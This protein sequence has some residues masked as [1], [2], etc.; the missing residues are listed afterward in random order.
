MHDGLV[1]IGTRAFCGLKFSSPIVFSKNL[2]SIGLGAFSDCTFAGGFSL[3]DGISSIKPDAFYGTNITGTLKLP[4]GIESIGGLGY[5][6][7]ANGTFGNTQIEKL[8]TGDNLQIINQYAFRNCLMLKSIE[9]GKNVSFIGEEAFANCTALNSIVC[10]AKEPPQLDPSAFVGLQA[11]NCV[12]EVPEESVG[13]YRAASGWS[14]FGNITPH[15]EL[16][17]SVTNITCLNKGISRDVILKAESEWEIAEI[18]SW[19]HV[20]SD[21]GGIGGGVV[22]VTIE[23]LASGS[24]QREGDIV[25]RL[26]DSGY[27]NYMTVRQYDYAY[28]ED[29]EIVLQSASRAG[30]SPIPVF[31][32]GEGYGAES[33]INGDFITRAHE[34]MEQLFALEP[35]KSYRDMFSVST[36]VSLSPVNAVM[37]INTRTE[38]KFSL[39]FPSIYD[40]DMPRLESYAKTLCQGIDDSNIGNTLIIVL[41]NCK[42][43]NGSARHSN[44]GCEFAFIGTPDDYYP[45]DNRGLVQHYAGGAAFGGLATENITHLD[46]IK[47][48][49]C[50]ECNG[51]NTYYTEKAAGR[52]ENVTLSGKMDEAPWREFMFHSKYSGIVDMYEGG[53]R[54]LRGVWR[55][56]ANSVMNTYI[57]YYN[58]I[59]RYAIY[60]EIMRKAGLNASLDEFIANDKIEIPQ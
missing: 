33:I 43:F 46:F 50:P 28:E 26:K 2:T 35:Y 34:T 36:A 44:D 32:V 10:L 6:I 22:K 47:S 16:S 29:K 21:G 30:C 4:K 25:F 58:T 56:E 3:N 37:D 27:T 24:G 23:P 52:Y 1:N 38:T 20:T 53:H 57:A 19:I 9:I 42:A 12:V 7:H 49:S 14:S 17:L 60:K 11:F 5:F 8:I 55:S 13:A 18:P 45:Y 15:H 31:I 41:A 54:H 48:C 51:M 40:N 59:S 39:I